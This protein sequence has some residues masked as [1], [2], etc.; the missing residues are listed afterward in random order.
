MREMGNNKS[1]RAVSEKT[2]SR[3]SMYRRILS[4]VRDTGVER[5]YSHDLA[6]MT[7]G[8][9]AQVRR[10]LMSVGYSGSPNRGYHVDDLMDSIGTFIDGPAVQPVALVGVGNLGRAILS[11]FTARRPML[12]IVAAFD[13]DPHKINRV[14]HGCMVYGFDQLENVLREKHIRVGVITVPGSEAQ[15]VA[16]RLVVGGVR[17]ILNLAPVPLRVPP[18]VYLEGLDMTASLET[19]AYFAGKGSKQQEEEEA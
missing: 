3:L 4:E 2:V 6:R 14:I 17:G 11:F 10:D 5:L 1:R 16:N 15:L 13:T 12:K 8:T 19:V 18:G 9:A 7:G